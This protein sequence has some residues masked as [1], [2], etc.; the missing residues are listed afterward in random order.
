[1][2]NTYYT[3]LEIVLENKK[4]VVFTSVNFNY[5][6]RALTLAR[7]V[8]RH[9][10][11]VY[12]VLLIVEPDF[13]FSRSTRDLLLSCDNGNSFDEIKILA[14]LN[15]G[16]NNDLTNYTV[17]E[18]CTA[19]KGQAAVDLLNR[20]TSQFVTYLDPDLFF[21]R[22]L[23][24]IRDEHL[25]GDVLLT[26][27]LNHAPYTN[28]IIYNDEIA[29]IM[30]HGLFNL[31]FVSFS[32]TKNGRDIA[33]WWADRLQ[34]SSKADYPNG[35]FT[36]QKWW[37]LS[38]IYFRD[39]RVVK[40][41]GWN[42]APWNVSERR[43]I[44]VNPPILDTGESLLFFHFSKFPSDAFNDKIKSQ[45]NSKV[46]EVL[47]SDYSSD[48]DD[49]NNYIENLMPNIKVSQIS[50]E[51]RVKLDPKR[52][53]KVELLLSRL[54]KFLAS[55]KI[56][57]QFFLK[58]P[59]RKSISKNIYAMFY[60]FLYKTEIIKISSYNDSF[61]KEI[62]IDLLIVTH[63][64]GGGV[65]QIIENELYKFSSDQKIVAI[66]KPNSA[67]SLQLMFNFSKVAFDVTGNLPHIL[68][69]SSRIDVH[70]L[71]GFEPYLNDFLTKEIDAIYLHDRYLINQALF[72]D[73]TQYTQIN[74]KVPGL[75]S[76]LRQ[77]SQYSDSA[78]QAMSRK[79]LNNSKQVFAPSDY[80][81]HEFQSV[82]PEN[83]V[84]KILWEQNFEPKEKSPKSNLTNH[85]FLISPTGLHK[86][87]SILV[88]V[89]KQLKISKPSILFE[90]FGDLE[91]STTEELD[92]LDNVFQIGQISR[93]RLNLALANSPNSIGWI[94]S[95]TGESYSLALSDFLSNG[96][97]VVASKTGALP[98]RLRKVPGNYLYDPA[99]P[100][101][102]LSDFFCNLTESRSLNKFRNFIEIT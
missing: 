33:G 26:P 51:E 96:I 37:D 57:R 39:T 97:T 14:D 18:M 31:G 65:A 72:S 95:L 10:P 43:L 79:V 34:I 8:K 25:N 12:F 20:N 46:L 77:D 71:L 74:Y 32:N 21:Y 70:H 87:S 41:D 94:P 81:I 62:N 28:Q 102:V 49:A 9:D 64:G 60:K 45:S 38:Q 36:D 48:F 99:I 52:S 13:E 54:L 6:G 100:S 75:N 2:G 85:I 44:S 22:S 16:Q 67:G 15:L 82:F 5:L 92:Q 3:Y 98:E 59:R 56:I 50:N 63:K 1:M 69:Q 53:P 42:M 58:S 83:K 24:E 40:S 30:R 73:T 76:P 11:T 19:V 84:K 78:W 86:G 101:I 89:A 66:L 4:H 93:N 88:E 29:G 61:L 68:A 91:A 23:G 90:V 47:V 27:H 55:H 80:I 7:S 35:L 17:V